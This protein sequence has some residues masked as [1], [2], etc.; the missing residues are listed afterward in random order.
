MPQG[1]RAVLPLCWKCA[2]SVGISQTPHVCQA[3]AQGLG[4][5]GQIGMYSPHRGQHA[6]SRG[7]QCG[8]SW[9]TVVSSPQQE[10]V[11]A[12]WGPLW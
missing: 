2:C 12:V 9:S 7:G 10:G 1:V 11:H 8:S 5:Q 4:S 3:Q 6:G